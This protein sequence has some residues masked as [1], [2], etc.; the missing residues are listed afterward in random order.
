M[1]LFEAPNNANT[2]HLLDVY[3]KSLT[4]QFQQCNSFNAIE[5]LAVK[6]IDLKQCTKHFVFE[7][8]NGLCCDLKN[9]ILSFVTNN[10][11]RTW[12]WNLKAELGL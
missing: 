8:T 10:V 12:S 11:G 9:V 6:S 3:N 2:L 4:S 5:L 7:V 1:K